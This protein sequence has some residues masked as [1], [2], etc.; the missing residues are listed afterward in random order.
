MLE[1][2][3]RKSSKYSSVFCCVHLH[4]YIEKRQT[5]A[6]KTHMGNF[7]EFGGLFV[8]FSFLKHFKMFCVCVFFSSVY[9]SRSRMQFETKYFAFIRWI[10][11]RKFFS[12]CGID[13]NTNTNTWIRNMDNDKQISCTRLMY[14][15][16][17][18]WMPLVNHE[19]KLKKKNYLHVT[20][21]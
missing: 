9:L 8:V 18:A 11:M 2:S 1:L 7:V 16:F 13:S 19:L 20:T 12:V 21:F 6:R 3:F 5:G 15:N 14:Y 4:T 10:R 17:Y